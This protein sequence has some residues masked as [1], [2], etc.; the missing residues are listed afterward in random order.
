ML[1]LIAKSSPRSIVAT[2]T[3]SGWVSPEA[4]PRIRIQ[5]QVVFWGV[6]PGRPSRG[7]ESE[8]GRG[9][10]QVSY[11]CSDWNLIPLRELGSL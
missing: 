3:V 11:L 6:I 9:G 7:G 4:N 10:N 5:R 2:F 1:T 8:T